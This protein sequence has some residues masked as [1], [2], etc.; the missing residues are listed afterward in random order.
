MSHDPA[1]ARYLVIS[2]VRLASAAQVLLGMA[3]IGGRLGLPYAVGAALV[4]AGVLEFFLVPRL[5]VRRWRSP[6]Q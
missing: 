2:L 3:I 5:L 6:D 1:R 4:L